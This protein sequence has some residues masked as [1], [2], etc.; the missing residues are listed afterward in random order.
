METMRQHQEG[1]R[2]NSTSKTTFLEIEKLA[3][4]LTSEAN[5]QL[6]QT[7]TADHSCRNSQR[8]NI[9]NYFRRTA[10]PQTSSGL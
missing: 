4:I 6:S 10:P 7:S 8:L 2:W 1:G 3:N 9:V 5:L